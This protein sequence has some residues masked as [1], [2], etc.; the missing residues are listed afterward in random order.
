MPASPASLPE[1]WQTE[2]C[3][4]SA[5]VRETLTELGVEFVARQVPAE[6]EDRAEMDDVVGTREIPA[7]RLPDGTTLT[8][9]TDAI[10]DSLRSRYPEPAGAEEHREKAEEKA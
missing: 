1:V 5:R 8:G 10:I 2:W 4:H 6:R 7:V 9:D 3:P